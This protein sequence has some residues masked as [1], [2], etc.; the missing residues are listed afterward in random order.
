MQITNQEGG[1][2]DAPGFQ[3]MS[4][5]MLLWQGIMSDYMYGL[6]YLQQQENP[7][8]KGSFQITTLIEPPIKYFKSAPPAKITAEQGSDVFLHW[9]FTYQIDPINSQYHPDQ[10][11]LLS[12]YKAEI[13][14]TS[15]V[16]RPQSYNIKSVNGELVMPEPRMSGQVIQKRQGNDVKVHV[17]LGITDI[18]PDDQSMITCSIDGTLT[19]PVSIQWSTEIIVAPNREFF[20][21]GYIG[22]AMDP[23]TSPDSSF[24]AM[25][26]GEKVEI[27][28]MGVGNDISN[29]YLTKDDQ[30]PVEDAEHTLSEVFRFMTNRQSV[31]YRIEHASEADFGTYACNIEDKYGRVVTTKRASVVNEDVQAEITVSEWNSDQV[32]RD[33]LNILFQN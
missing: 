4:S 16:F 28:C 8:D 26:L 32:S 21:S 23:W 18:Q 30:Q 19:R 1:F 29:T 20:P 25:T 17:T 14:P 12:Q 27:L 7:E 13:D 6:I 10:I 33:R 24:V 3:L 5:D 22:A 31:M 2:N 15:P 9:E 11:V